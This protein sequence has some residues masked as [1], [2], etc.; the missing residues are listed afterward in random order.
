MVEAMRS[1]DVGPPTYFEISVALAFMHFA[2]ADVDVALLEVGIGGRLDATN[3][4]EPLISVITPISFDHTDVLGTTL[5]AIAGEKAGIIRPGG[6]VVLAPQPDEAREVIAARCRELGARLIE[7]A[8]DVRWERQ[9]GGPG[10]QRFR[11]MGRR[12]AYDGLRLPLVGAH[13]V[14]N[15]ATAVAAA[16]ALGEVGLPVAADAVARG[17]AAVRWPGRVEVLRRRPTVV[18]DVAHNPAAIAAL[19]DALVE[20]FPGRRILLLFGMLSTKDYRGAAAIIAPI[21]DAIVVTTPD[22]PHALPAAILAD[23]ARG[24]CPRVEVVESRLAALDRILRLA[25]P[26]DVICVTGSFYLVG[27]LRPV[28]RRRRRAGTPITA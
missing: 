2:R 7:V 18:L 22:H 25:R 20:C 28:L 9:Q 12:G 26:E 10:G 3:V 13:Q 17:L 23:A 8:R 24:M 5:S 16:E 1:S 6:V 19:R 15:A 11:V 14:V 21:A 4:A 27:E